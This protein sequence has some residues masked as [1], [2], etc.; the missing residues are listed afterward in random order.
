MIELKNISSEDLLQEL[1]DRKVLFPLGYR[2]FG[3]VDSPNGEAI[4][5]K[6]EDKIHDMPI[7]EFYL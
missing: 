1:I 3:L 2:T 4:M 5:N 7:H 6:I